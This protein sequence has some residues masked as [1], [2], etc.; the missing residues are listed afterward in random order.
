MEKRA[1]TEIEMMPISDLLAELDLLGGWESMTVLRLGLYAVSNFA[2]IA[3]ADSG[4]QAVVTSVPYMYPPYE[5]L[6]L[7][8]H[9]LE[10][11]LQKELKG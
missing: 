11:F 7:E 3:E 8:A 1:R 6:Y 4:T 9:I 5:S 2:P 10:I